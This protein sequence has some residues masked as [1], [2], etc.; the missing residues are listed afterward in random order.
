MFKRVLSGMA[1]AGFVLLLSGCGDKVADKPVTKAENKAAPKMLA[2]E[3]TL[4]R[5]SVLPGGR[6]TT[7]GISYGLEPISTSRCSIS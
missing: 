1:A 4:L 5:Y 2:P 6:M 7:V 3:G